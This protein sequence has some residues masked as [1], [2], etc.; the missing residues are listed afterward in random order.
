MTTARPE[1]ETISTQQFTPSATKSNDT[2]L[3]HHDLAASVPLDDSQRSSRHPEATQPA[4]LTG[5]NA[6]GNDSTEGV[7]KPRRGDKKGKKGKGKRKCGEKRRSHVTQSSFTRRL[8]TKEED[9]AITTLVQHYGIRKWTL[10]SK[11]LQDKYH[12]R[13]RSGKQCRERYGSS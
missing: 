4:T 3:S 8:W 13:G 11:K 2:L 1:S 7:T 9:E 5:E 6:E 12:I 10:I